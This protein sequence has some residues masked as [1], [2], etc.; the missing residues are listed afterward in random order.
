MDHVLAALECR[1]T[2][3]M[4]EKIAKPFTEKEVVHAIKQMHPTKA[5]GPDGMTPL[6]YQRFWLIIKHDVLNEVLGIL[7]NSHNPISLNHTHV[8]LIPKVKNPETPKDFRPISLCNVVF[9][10]SLKL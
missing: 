9:A 1:V 3:E 7:N 6:F 2:D 4:N 10:S 5:P 8:I